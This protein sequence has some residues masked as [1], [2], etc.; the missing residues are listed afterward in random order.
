[1]TT[2]LVPVEEAILLHNLALRERAASR[3]E[4]ALQAEQAAL[5]IFDHH[6]DGMPT[7]V[8]TALNTVG[9]IHEELGRYFDAHAA[10]HRALDVLNH[11]NPPPV[12]L[13]TETLSGACPW[14]SESPHLWPA[15]GPR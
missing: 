9:L 15:V 1:M 14:P 4:D 2:D 8:A 5:D 7:H 6:P 10:F 12:Q 13:W 11:T 3:L